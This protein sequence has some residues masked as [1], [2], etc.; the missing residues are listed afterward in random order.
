MS[1]IDSYGSV[2]VA[3][4]GGVD[5]ALLAVTAAR[6][7]ASGP[8]RHR[9]ESELPHAS[10]A[11][12]ADRG[13]AVRPPPRVHLHRRVEPARVP[14]QSREPLLLLQDRALLHAGG[15]GAGPRH[16]RG[17]RWQQRRRSRRLP[18]RPPSRARARR[19]QPARRG[20]IDQGRNPRAGARPWHVHV[21][22]ARVGL[23]VV[24]RALSHRDHRPGAADD[25]ARRRRD[26]ANSASV[27]AACATTT[28][29]A[30]LELGADELPRAQQPEWRDKI[31]LVPFVR[32]V[33]RT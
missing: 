29:L 23:P 3:F 26:C 5:S 20:G 31:V 11:A 27:S 1:L 4:S 28:T 9:R 25:R 17:R 2:I 12:G 30:R 15:D 33:T 16:G 10:P 19:V 24:A 21:G 32:L 14:R 18:A 7:W 6:G 22:R 13:A 8:V